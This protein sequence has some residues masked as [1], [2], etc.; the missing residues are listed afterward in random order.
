MQ[1]VLLI[2]TT[3]LSNLLAQQVPVVMGAILIQASQLFQQ[4]QSKNYPM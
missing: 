1:K 2:V 3:S 4:L